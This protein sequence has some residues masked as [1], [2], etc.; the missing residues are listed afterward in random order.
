[1][2]KNYSRMVASNGISSKNNL[3]AVK[4]SHLINYMWEPDGYA[5]LL[6]REYVHS[7]THPTA[8][9]QGEGLW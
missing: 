3:N 7:Q 1:M 5:R 4:N 8:I 6:L 9:K 2:K